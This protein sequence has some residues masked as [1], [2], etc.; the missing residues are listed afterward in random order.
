[1]DWPERA[2]FKKPVADQK[3]LKYRETAKILVKDF[4]GPG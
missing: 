4:N 1:M 2:F 3:V